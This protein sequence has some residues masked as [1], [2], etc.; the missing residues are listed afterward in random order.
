MNRGQIAAVYQQEL[1]W[2]K[3]FANKSG[4]IHRQDRV[5]VNGLDLE[6]HNGLKLTKN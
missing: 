3:G 1:S 6:R 5:L 2:F 4:K